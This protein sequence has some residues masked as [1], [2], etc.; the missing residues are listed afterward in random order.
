ME[1]LFPVAFV[2]AALIMVGLVAFFVIGFINK[3]SSLESKLTGIWINESE[4]QRI[5]LHHID[6]IFQADIVWMGNKENE[7]LLGFRMIKNLVPK[8]FSL[9]ISGTYTDPSTGSEHPVKLRWYG[10][11]RIKLDVFSKI[12]GRLKVIKREIWRQMS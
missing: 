6:S 10:G 9:S 1:T 3:A 5:I 2:V 7:R 12:N 4:T 11:S 8:K